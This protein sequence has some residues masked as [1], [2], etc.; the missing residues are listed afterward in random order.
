M[1]TITVSN[2]DIQLNNGKIQ[3]STG[4][5]KLI[6]DMNRWLTEP[7]GTG[8]TT[9]GFGSLLPNYIGQPQIAGQS[10]LIENEIV[11]VLQLYIGQ[12]TLDLQSAQNSAQLSNW[13]RSEIIQSVYSINSQVQGNAVLVSVAL[14][15]LNQNLVNINININ[16]TGVSVT[17]G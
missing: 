1:K 4:S 7:L 2:G 17:N 14:Q 15:T 13:N 8:W 12:Q 9:P 11:R 10:S 5:D 3:F 16:N 6:Q